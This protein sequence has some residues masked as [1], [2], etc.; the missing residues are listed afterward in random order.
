VT[1]QNADAI[2]RMDAL[3]SH[4]S[5]GDSEED[6]DRAEDVYVLDLGSVE[7]WMCEDPLGRQ[8]EDPVL[9]Q[10][11]EWV[12]RGDKPSPDKVRATDP[13]TD[14]YVWSF[15]R[16]AITPDKGLV[17]QKPDNPEAQV[18]LPAEY[19]D[20]VFDWAHC[21]PS[22]GHFGVKATLRKFNRRC[23][24][25][26][27]NTRIAT[28]VENCVNCV[29]KRKTV[30]KD[31]YVF[32]RTIETRPL[33][34]VYIDLVGPF[35]E[36]RYQEHRY[37]YVLTMMDGFT[38]WAQAIL[39]GDITAKTVSEE[40]LEHWVARYGIPNCIHTDQGLQFTSAVFRKTMEGLGI[41]TTN[42][43]AYNPRSNKVERLHRVLGDVLQS[44]QTGPSEDWV[45]K[46]PWALFAY[47]TTVSNVTG[48]TLF[49]AMFGADSRVS[50]D[51]IFP[52]PE[53][54]VA[55]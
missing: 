7:E 1:N 30:Q 34:R 18:C 41:K 28:A 10:V 2:S 33:D 52:L 36:C 29:Q 21:H 8:K 16:L 44:N 53:G 49:R 46:L 50:L 9:A 24:L 48:T 55:Q 5:D 26:G 37:T 42:T 13:L 14:L 15:E 32:H 25:P 22:A 43:P 23:F 51:V 31:Q 45:R 4:G 11:I 6:R 12:T 19:F 20:K 3:P 35:P 54:E 47:R 17:Y 39:V 40:V 27:A 38:R